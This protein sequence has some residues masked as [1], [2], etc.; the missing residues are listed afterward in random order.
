MY[1]NGKKEVKKVVSDVKS[2]AHDDLYNKLGTRGERLSS[3][4]E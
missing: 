3:L 1:K 4:Q 2:K